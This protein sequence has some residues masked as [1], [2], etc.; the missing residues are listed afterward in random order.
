MVQLVCNN[1]EYSTTHLGQN[2]YTGLGWRSTMSMVQL[3]LDSNEHG[4]TQHGEIS[5]VQ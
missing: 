5:I 4:T 3:V 2:G 1:N